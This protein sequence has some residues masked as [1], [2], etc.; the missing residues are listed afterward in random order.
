MSLYTSSGSGLEY[1]V[2]GSD[3]N[4]GFV[5]LALGF[6]VFVDARL[7]VQGL[8]WSAYGVRSAVFRGPGFLFHPSWHS[9]SCS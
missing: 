1:R 5:E 3:F 2:L 9:L 8:A 4:A 7:R 6:S